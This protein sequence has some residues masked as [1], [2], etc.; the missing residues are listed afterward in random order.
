MAWWYFSFA[1]EDGF[2]G[3]VYAE[4][5]PDLAAYAALGLMGLNPGGECQWIG[6]LP[7]DEM[8]RQVPS[9]NRWRLLTKEEVLA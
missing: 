4:G 1:D 5:E 9:E 6:P 3:G 7:D 8:D 2:L